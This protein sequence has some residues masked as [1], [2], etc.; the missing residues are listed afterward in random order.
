MRRFYELLLLL[1]LM[2]LWVFCFSS[3][4]EFCETKC[5]SEDSGR[6]SSQVAERKKGEGGNDPELLLRE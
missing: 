5:E 2:L 6:E 4:G 3:L 1:M